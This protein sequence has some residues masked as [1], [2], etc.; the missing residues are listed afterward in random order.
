MSRLITTQRPDLAP[1]DTPILLQAFESF[2]HRPQF[3]MEALGQA[4]S[5]LSGLNMRFEQAV[6]EAA[7][8]RQEDDEAQMEAEFVALKSLE[9]A[10]LWLQLKQGSRFRPYLRRRRVAFL[11]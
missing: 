11:S 9:R 2:G 6:L 10:V 5:P 4:L 3:F 7:Q 8:R 1:V